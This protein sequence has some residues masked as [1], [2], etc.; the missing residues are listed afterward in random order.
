MIP[1]QQEQFKIPREL[2]RRP[3]RPVRRRAGTL[4]CGVIGGRFLALVF[5][6]AGFFLVGRIPIVIAVVTHGE[7]HVGTVEKTWSSRGRR[8]TSYHVR[9]WYEAGGQVRSDSRT[10]SRAEFDQ[11]SM[12]PPTLPLDVRALAIQGTYF[13]QMYLPGESLWG[14]VWIA[15]LVAVLMNGFACLI[16][17]FIWIVPMQHKRLCREGKP[18][19]GRITRMHST[20]G[21]TTTYYLDYEFDHPSVGVRVASMSVPRE[22][23]HQAQVGEIVTVLCYPNRKR[24]T[25]MYEYGDFE[26]G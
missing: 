12:N 20:H 2:E 17:Y 9:Y 19:L 4:G 6:G 15:V 18:I 1:S 24:P 5:I 14:P 23:W 25:V 16:G 8:S 11:L 13:D 10:I 7:S 3:P 22:R 26:C 21:K